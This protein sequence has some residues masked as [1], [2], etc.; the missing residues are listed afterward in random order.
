MSKIINI[1]EFIDSR[2]ALYVI[3]N[4]LPFEVKRIYYI[5][6]IKGLR[7]G[8]RHKKTRQALICV[9]GCCNVF[10]NDGIN[11]KNYIL[12]NPKKCL[13][14]EPE[15]WHTMRSDID[16]TTLLILASEF[17]DVE[18]YIDKSYDD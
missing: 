4:T 1:P 3:E 16:L 17:Y 9:A 2:G 11:K 13:I 7:G 8:H 6:K 12:N 15:D 18:D 14:L 10:V 5:C